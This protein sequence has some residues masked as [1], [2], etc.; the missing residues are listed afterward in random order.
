M[1]SFEYKA[2]SQP[3]E[4]SQKCSPDKLRFQLI[5]DDDEDDF[6]KLKDKKQKI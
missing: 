1:D 4:I 6:Q 3:I 2:I 5:Q